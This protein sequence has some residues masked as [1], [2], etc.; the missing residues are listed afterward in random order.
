MHDQKKKKSEGMSQKKMEG[1]EPED[2]KWGSGEKARG[3]HL[4]TL[5]LC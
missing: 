2:K 5:L 4:E 3:K 1:L